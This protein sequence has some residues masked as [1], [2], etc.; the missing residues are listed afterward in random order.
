MPF[1]WESDRWESGLPYIH[2]CLGHFLDS[3]NSFSSRKANIGDIQPHVCAV[4]PCALPVVVIESLPTPFCSSLQRIK[5]KS[6]VCLERF[7]D[8]G[9]LAIR[10]ILSEL[11]VVQ[12]NACSP[13]SD[14]TQ[15][16]H[17][18]SSF[19]SHGQKCLRAGT[20]KCQSSEPSNESGVKAGERLSFPREENSCVTI[21]GH[22]RV[23][24]VKN[25]A[26][27]WFTTTCNK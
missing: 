1:L 24:D 10:K 14:I 27:H 26:I 21:F 19:P 2:S 11:S 13:S 23:H 18:L 15:H 9:S 16:G 12:R 6:N 3:A 5:V 17:A 25:R 22:V 7:F 4:S 20:S 8:N